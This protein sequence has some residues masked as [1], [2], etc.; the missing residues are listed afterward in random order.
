MAVSRVVHVDNRFREVIAS[1]QAAYR[2]QPGQPGDPILGGVMNR[3][4]ALELLECQIT[5]RWIDFVARELK[6]EGKSFYTIGSS[7]HEGNAMVGLLTRPTDP[8]FLHY[9]SG[10]F[11]FA[12]SRQVPGSTPVFDTCLSLTA[13][14][15]DPIS[16]GRHKVWG[17]LPLNIPP[18]TSTIAS[19]L[20][21]A[22]G[23]A[24]FLDRRAQL[25]TG[26]DLPKD[27]IVVCS[28]GD[29]SVN[30]STAVGA[31]N[32]AAWTAYQNLPAPVLF[33]CEDNGI[34][35]SVHTPMEW[36]ASNYGNRAGLKYFRADG[37]DIA[38]GYQTVAE[39]VA[40]CRSRRRPVFLHMRTVRLLGHAGSDVETSY[41][42]REQ[43]EAAEAQDPLLRTAERVI[44]AGILSPAEVL[45]LYDTIADQVRRAGAE[46]AQRP[47]HVTAASVMAP[48][49]LD[50]DTL[51]EKP[52]AE[53]L[54][55]REQYW[56]GKLPE[57]DKPKHLAAHINSAL[58]DLFLKERDLVLFG[59]DV[60]KK[61]GVYNVTT[62]LNESFGVGRVFNTLLD[63]QTILGLA[64]GAGH[65][66][67][68]PIPEI[69]YLAYLH[70][71]IDQLRG[72]AGSMRFFS[73]G[74]YTNPM[75]VRIAGFAYQKGF[76]G[77][78]HND[79][80]IAA[81]RELTGVMVVTCSN[82]PDAARLLRTAT[83]LARSQ[84]AIV[85]FIEPIALYM[86]K[87]LIGKE[88]W[89]FP[90]PAPGDCMPFGETHFHGDAD[91]ETLVISYANGYYLSRQ[92]C[93][94]LEQEGIRTAIL[95]LRWLKPL[96]AEAIV[97]AA[98]GRKR[99]VIVDEC[100]ITASISE[101][102]TTVLVEGLQ[103]EALPQISRVCGD[104]TFIPLGQAWEFVL[105][106][107]ES[108]AAAIRGGR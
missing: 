102:I 9:R 54:A 85:V 92:A 64:I 72:E 17:S 71:A 84:G 46:A 86:T 104:D 21:K 88:D 35:I 45:D 103:H 65:A 82:G 79:N 43:I 24:V 106:S 40:Y 37:L 52:S 63:E 81:L 27:A 95:E 25:K 32:A 91:A 47:K 34:G 57:Q 48:L 41:H 78:F 38:A 59:E 83:H 20:P 16:G 89:S 61:G 80:A 75:V 100:R 6:G 68:V 12:R 26:I 56:R 101:Q 10:G 99:V 66:G 2:P 74:Q 36:V 44:E 76:G 33:V 31:L 107:R 55:K 19:H 8:A 105:P 87:G 7:G 50:T 18:Q 96:N 14:S 94:D 97:A 93:H 53:Y 15:E 3:A 22:L 42:S 5:S 30:H 29:A 70:N 23:M 90:Y 28:F 108:I 58:I 11:F 98:R 39:A 62:G 1:R 77:H 67:L 4:T 51:P 60:A 49:M 69:Q 73:D 13:S